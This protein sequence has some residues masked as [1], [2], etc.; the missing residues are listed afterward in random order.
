MTVTRSGRQT[1][2]P[3]LYEP[4]EVPVDDYDDCSS[5]DSADIGSDNGSESESDGEDGD[6]N[7]NLSGFVVS[8]DESDCDN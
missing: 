4:E 8:D 6:E 1:K 5:D 3:V 7:G 2:K